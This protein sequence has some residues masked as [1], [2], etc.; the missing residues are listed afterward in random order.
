MESGKY[1]KSIEDGSI[2]EMPYSTSVADALLPLKPGTLPF[3]Y[4]KNN[5]S[6]VIPVTDENIIIAEKLLLGK[7]KI[8]LEIS[9][10][11]VIGAALQN[12][13]KFKKW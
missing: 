12:R 2:L 7:G 6:D 8:L 9:S 11:I 5:L 13:N 4:I 10:A 1:I 3:E